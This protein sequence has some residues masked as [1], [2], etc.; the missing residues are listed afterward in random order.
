[1]AVIL[2]EL[3]RPMMTQ[4]PDVD[5]F[6]MEEFC[7]YRGEEYRVRDNGSVLRQAKAGKRRRPL[8]EIWTFGTPSKSDGY[9]AISGHKVHR[10]VATAFLGEQP[11]KGHIVDHIDTNRRNNRHDN[12]RWITRLE[13]ILL[14]PVTAKRI[15][16]LYGSI[17]DFLAD[18]CNPKNGTLTADFEW[19]RTVTKD[20]AEYSLERMLVWAASGRPSGGGS[21]GDWI[22]RRSAAL[23]EEPRPKLV[24]S[25]TPGAVQRNWQVP[26]EFPLCPEPKDEAPLATYFPCLQEGAVA[27]IS[28][29]GETK[30]GRAAMS[31]DGTAI[32]ILGSHGGDAIKP[33]SLAQITFED[34]Q[35]VHESCGTFFTRD[36]AE[37]EFTLI[38]GLSWEGGETFDDYC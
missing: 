4:L 6:E 5:V 17:E 23:V 3:R 8:D 28:P 14:N 22:F 1:M 9:M 20:E 26:A 37:K 7:T 10:I 12:L 33:W 29:W 11:S 16:Y 38:Q 27:V 2:Y 36:G 19:M 32:F 34:G 31:E 24:A 18:P 30:V 13:N 15:E 25:K 35:Y 21:L